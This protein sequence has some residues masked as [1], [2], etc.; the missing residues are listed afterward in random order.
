M[1]SAEL[2][3]T[4]AIVVCRVPYQHRQ[5]YS[6][7]NVGVASAG[8]PDSLHQAVPGREVRGGGGAGAPPR[9]APPPLQVRREGTVRGGTATHTSQGKEILFPAM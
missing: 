7:S 8:V 1:C 5:Y 6:T 3:L 9:P 4:T 2:I